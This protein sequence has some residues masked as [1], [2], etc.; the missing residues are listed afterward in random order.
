MVNRFH[1]INSVDNIMKCSLSDN[2]LKFMR[3]FRKID[4]SINYHKKGKREEHMNVIVM[5]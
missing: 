1:E 2:L 5:P 3:K 4:L